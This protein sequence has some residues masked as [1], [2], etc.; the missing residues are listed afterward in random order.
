[1]LVLMPVVCPWV[2]VASASVLEAFL[3]APMELELLACPLV[4]RSPVPPALETRALAAVAQ[5]K[6]AAPPVPVVLQVAHWD[7]AQVAVV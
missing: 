1:M 3:W 7:Q 5:D 2:Q 4:V 6:V